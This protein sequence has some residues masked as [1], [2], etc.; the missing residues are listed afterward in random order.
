[1]LFLN[2]YL[3]IALSILSFVVIAALLLV[4]DMI[5][6]AKMPAGVDKTV[7]IL[8]VGKRESFNVTIANLSEAGI[9]KDPIRFKLLALIKRY[10]T[11]IK[12]GE[13]ALSSLM[14]PAVILDM[15]V[16]G[17]TYLHK[18][19]IPEG[20][21]LRQ[22]AAVIS[23]AGFGTEED[24]IKKTTDPSFVSNKGI[25]AK[26]LEGYI[27]PD[28]YYFPKDESVED[29]VSAMVER[30]WAVF[31]PE[32]K[33][34]ANE[35]GFS[36]HQIITLASI[37]EKETGD[38][39]ERELISSVFYNRLKKGMRLETDPT[40]IYGI[41]KFDG[42]ITRKHLSTKTPYNTYQIE[43]LPPGPIASPGYDSIKASL[44]PA[45]TPYIFFVSKNDGTH[46]FS[47]N[48]KEHNR[49]VNKY[50]RSKDKEPLSEINSET[51]SDALQNNQKIQPLT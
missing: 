37:I 16:R 9:I 48:F 33:E 29:I 47:A 25:E 43:G 10:D 46:Y 32:W 20:Y 50:Q 49:A 23:G 14:P 44:Y 38:K 41:K 5:D 31:K 4:F 12:A 42:N 34:R 35:L 6:Y 17:K 24:F 51:E 40:V 19:T 15:M 26:S 3:I 2:K 45:E 18:V 39:H 28:T 36:I 8:T 30:L 1:M 7:K 21:N 27:Y 22:I 13:Y 11:K